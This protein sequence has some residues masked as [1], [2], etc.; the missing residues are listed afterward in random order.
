MTTHDF[1][2]IMTT[3]D[4]DLILL[5]SFKGN[6][7][8]SYFEAKRE[9]WKCNP[10]EYIAGLLESFKQL[11]LLTHE[12]DLNRGIIT[13]Q[14]GDEVSVTIR[15]NP[16]EVDY[17]NDEDDSK[18]AWEKE[19]A[20]Y[21]SIGKVSFPYMKTFDVSEYTEG[22]LK[23]I[24]D[25]SMTE[26][27]W[28]HLQ[29]YCQSIIDKNAEASPPQQSE[30]IEA[31]AMTGQPEAKESTLNHS[32]LFKALSKYIIEINAIGF[33]H[34]IEHHSLPQDGTP[35]ANWIG[36]PVDAHRFATHI[37]MKIS[38]WNKCFYGITDKQGNPR[39]LNSGDKD[40]QGMSNMPIIEILNKHL[41]K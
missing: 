30:G 10:D 17:S 35:Q 3:H 12:R 33:S 22:K 26:E 32:E 18:T 5:E 20:S 36:A 23:G 7:K 2:S 29:E 41:S 4:F 6:T 1:D 31:K 37:G 13:K 38:V 39:E 27:L 9:Q 28:P 21:G 25:A 14:N 19:V 8:Q 40:K 24:I 15:N 11:D 16:V 34:I